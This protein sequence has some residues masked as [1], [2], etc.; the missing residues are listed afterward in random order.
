MRLR[1]YALGDHLKS[2]DVG[3]GI[4]VNL[5]ATLSWDAMRAI[6]LNEL[7]GDTID[8]AHVDLNLVSLHLLPDGERVRGPEFLSANDKVVLYVGLT[9]LSG[10]IND[11]LN[12]EGFKTDMS[13]FLQNFRRSGAESKFEQQRQAAVAPTGRSQAMAASKSDR[14]TMKLPGSRFFSSNQ[15]DAKRLPASAAG[16]LTRHD[17]AK[18]SVPGQARSPPP[19][20]D[21]KATSDGHQPHTIHED[22]SGESDDSEMEGLDAAVAPTAAD[23]AEDPV[24]S[25]RSKLRAKFRAAIQK[26]VLIHRLVQLPAATGGSV[27]APKARDEV[28]S[29]KSRAANN[30]RASIAAG[31]FARAD[32]SMDALIKEQ[33]NLYQYNDLRRGSL[34]DSLPCGV[35]HPDGTMRMTWDVAMLCLVVFFGFMVP[36]RLGFDITLSPA[37]ESFDLVADILF[38]L[39]LASNFRTAY[40]DDGVMVS[41]GKA[42]AMNYLKS[43]FFIDLVASFPIGW[44]TDTGGVNKVI[45]MLRLFKLFRMLRLLRL[46]PRFTQV[47]EASIKLNPAMIG[48]LRS[49]AIMFLM[50]HNIGCA[51]WFVAREELNG[52]A[53]CPEEYGSK[54]CYV[55]HCVCDQSD[56]VGS[57]VL[58]PESDSSWYDPHNPDQWVPHYS[59]PSS[60]IL[61]QYGQ[62]VFWAV[63]VTTGIGGDIIPRSTLE[64]FFTAF[65]VI[66]GLMM[67]SLIIG[68]ASSALANIDSTATQRRQTLEKVNAFMRSRKVPPFFQRIIV[69]FYEHMWQTPQREA[70]V[71]R[72][73]PPSLRSRL[74]IVMNRDLI[75][76]IPIFKL[77][78]ASVYVRIVQRL[79]HNTFLPGEYVIQQGTESEFLYF[80]KRG[81]C[82]ALLPDTEH[83]IF[84]TLFPGDVFGERGLLFDER[85]S[86]SYRAVDF[87]DVLMM[88]QLEF[89]EL[90][91]M[92]PAFVAELRRVAAVRERRRIGFELTLLRRANKVMPHKRTGFWHKLFSARRGQGIVQAD[93]ATKEWTAGA[94]RRAALKVSPAPPD[95]VS[96]VSSPRGGPGGMAEG[97][98]RHQP[99]GAR[100]PF[101]SAS[102]AGRSSWPASVSEVPSGLAP[103][104]GPT[105]LDGSKRSLASGF[106][107]TPSQRGL[108]QGL[109]EYRSADGIPDA[110]SRRVPSSSL[111]Q[112][113]ASYAGTSQRNAWAKRKMGTSSAVL[114]ANPKLSQATRSSAPQSMD[115]AVGI[116]DD[117]G[118]EER[119]PGQPRTE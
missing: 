3:T 34:D 95:H 58:L 114:P 102:A 8:I 107:A 12:V 70:D 33:S 79:Q 118:A 46:F 36:Y 93:A 71:F 53:V 85:R 72:D 10:D 5:S 57:H 31:L 94:T 32:K 103:S 104:M 19:E 100:R 98:V 42:M 60:D 45:R 88:S 63:E 78:S 24:E 56:P 22:E 39:D 20:S 50:W 81:K 25:H 80:V 11:P 91:V 47:L 108:G 44:F 27:Y 30:W 23:A 67:Y 66:V 40:K 115:S 59:M 37:E 75:D 89:Q 48:F 87:L 111:S 7:F 65:M 15:V 110:L 117:V 41:D 83:T 99:S 96:T 76:R 112:R 28:P 1:L 113:S 77:M 74:A 105:N 52:I 64:V 6:L 38:L 69:D 49:F 73:L 9:P 26:L 29:S 54:P 51:Y 13:T 97:S 109:P 55:N 101:G 90:V 21:A 16:P 61:V 4:L 2:S 35:I 84:M 18:D 116:P 92:S 68:S 14:G 119:L 86:E 62:A 82:D 17:S 43:W 106:E